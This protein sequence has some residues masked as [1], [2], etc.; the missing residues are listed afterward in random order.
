[1]ITLKHVE[2]VYSP[3]IFIAAFS[4]AMRP[5]LGAKLKALSATTT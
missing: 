4:P 1:M 2:L 5:E 3:S